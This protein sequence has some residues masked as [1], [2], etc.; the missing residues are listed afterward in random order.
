[1][2]DRDGLKSTISF[3]HAQSKGTG[4]SLLLDESDKPHERQIDGIRL[5]TTV[6]AGGLL[7]DRRR[8]VQPGAS[9]EAMTG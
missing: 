1:M 7:S 4:R 3:G 9:C 6:S 2:K 8:V 5:R